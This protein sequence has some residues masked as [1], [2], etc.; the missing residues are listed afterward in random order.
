LN[1]HWRTLL[2]VPGNRPERFDK[3]LLSGADAVCLDLEDAVAASSQE[4]AREQVVQALQSGAKTPVVVRLNAAGTPWHESDIARLD[5]LP[6]TVAFMLPKARLSSVQQL[7]SRTK[8]RPLFALIE[9]A[10]GIEE[11]YSIAAQEG[12]RGLMLG[13]ADLTAELGAS[14]TRDSLFY[15]RSRLLMAASSAGRM[16]IDV[17]CLALKDE[18]TIAEET[19]LVKALGYSCKAVIHPAQIEPVHSV[20]TPSAAE[21]ERAESM[22]AALKA[23]DGDAVEW[24]G[25]ML[26]EPVIA[27]ARR[28]LAQ[29]GRNT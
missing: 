2:F 10:L 1:Y 24:Q 17:P 11:A 28:I 19:H 18:H 5:C 7:S 29:A 6:E 23:S 12:V 9:T 3:A 13:G 15:A 27:S 21:I 8:G 26:D 16:A 4:S 22:L 14:M 20:L 25:T